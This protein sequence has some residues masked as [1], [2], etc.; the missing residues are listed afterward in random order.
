MISFT[1][2]QI[3][4]LPKAGFTLAEVLFAMAIF[5]FGVLVMV[6]T[7]PNG[8]ASMQSAQRQM[9]E[10][11]IFQHLLAVYQSELD[12]SLAK[13]LNGTL[14]RLQQPANF[15]FDNRGD[16]LRTAMATSNE[17]AFGAQASLEPAALLPGE[18]VPSPFSRR[19]RI[20]VAE[21]WQN[22]NAFT[23]PSLHRQRV[24]PIT[25]TGP[26]P[27]TTVAPTT[28]DPPPPPST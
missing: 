7:L 4:Q 27:P 6:G 16:P 24:I 5:I 12:R 20:V 18:T 2:S 8:L 23:N 9:A 17:A 26:L 14:A 25:L 3:R 1:P 21:N 10:V 19:L 15:F 28:S 11:R 13:D 22:P